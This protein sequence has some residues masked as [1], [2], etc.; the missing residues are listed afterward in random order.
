[1]KT[2]PATSAA[3]LLA[4]LETA[5]IFALGTQHDLHRVRNQRALCDMRDAICSATGRDHQEVQEHYEVLAIIK[6][7]QQ[8]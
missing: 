5:Y 8:G 3:N 1:M 6:K 2:E 4:A 7:A